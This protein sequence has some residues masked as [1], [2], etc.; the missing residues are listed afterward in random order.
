MAPGG[1]LDNG[2]LPGGDHRIWST[3][4]E[5]PDLPRTVCGSHGTSF[6][7]PHVAAAAA[8]LLARH[9]RVE[10]AAVREALIRSA[11]RDGLDLEP[12]QRDD[13]Y[14]YGRPDR[15]RP[16]AD[17]GRRQTPRRATDLRRTGSRSLGSDRT[18]G[19]N[20]RRRGT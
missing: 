20:G 12:G 1:D 10:P 16:G 14:G 19:T 11:D 6:A 4:V 7:E 9:P 17:H 2:I 15:R 8:I 5:D 18:A 3:C 13:E